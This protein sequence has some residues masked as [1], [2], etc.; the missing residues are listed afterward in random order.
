[1]PKTTE[2]TRT[3]SVHFWNDSWVRKLNA[4]DRYAF[5][6]F[7]TN[8]H[9]TWCGIYELDISMAAFESGIDERDLEKSILPR[10]SP[11]ILFVDGWICVRNWYK[12]HASNLPGVTKGV[13]EALKEV[14]EEIRLKMDTLLAYPLTTPCLSVT[15]ASSLAL[16]SAFSLT[17][18]GPLRGK[19]VSPLLDPSTGRKPQ[20]SRGFTNAYRAKNGKPPLQRTKTAKQHRAMEELGQVD[21][22]IRKHRRMAEK[23]TGAD[24]SFLDEEENPKIR[25][26][27]AL[28]IPKVEK[29]GKTMDQ[30][31]AYLEKNEFAK[32]NQYNP[33]LCYTES[34]MVHFLINGDRKESMEDIARRLLKEARAKGGPEHEEEDFRMWARGHFKKMF[35][36]DDPQFYNGPVFENVKHI[37]G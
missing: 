2:K 1:M 26:L 7:L 30:Y 36:P 18:E 16:A 31:L 33:L 4:L 12:Y 10:L 13:A 35:G 37:I 3:V 22:V 29:H 9:T 8:P 15:S 34:M 28:T 32:K 23:E 11:R 6:Y 21:E 25:R 20:G 24:Y 5:L 27:V 17:P 14:P 19:K